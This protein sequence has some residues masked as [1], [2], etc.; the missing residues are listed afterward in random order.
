MQDIRVIVL[1]DDG[2]YFAQC[3]EVDV[4][5]QGATPEEAIA[6]LKNVLNAEAEE[7]RN[8][9]R[10]LKDIGPAPEPYRALDAR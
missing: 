10:S 9:G 4:A 6:R 8:K 7:L 5:A 3:L 2:L 1:K